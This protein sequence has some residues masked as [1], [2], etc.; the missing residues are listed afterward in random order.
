MNLHDV[1]NPNPN[2]RLIKT[3]SN[4]ANLMSM[5]SN[6]GEQSCRN[7]RQVSTKSGI[8]CVHYTDELGPHIA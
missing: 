6:G 3:K 8:E 7:L 2:H 4:H 5:S 1:N